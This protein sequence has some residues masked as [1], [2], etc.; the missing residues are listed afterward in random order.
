MQDSIITKY[1]VE[2][3]MIH[4]CN[5]WIIISCN[6]FPFV[7]FILIK[8][9]KINLKQH[10]RSILNLLLWN[11]NVISPWRATNYS[12][13]Q[14]SWDIS[15]FFMFCLGNGRSVQWFIEQNSV[16][17]EQN[18][19]WK[20][21]CAHCFSNVEVSV[22]ARPIHGRWG[23][24]YKSMLY[25]TDYVFRIIVVLDDDATGKYN[26]ASKSDATIFS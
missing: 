9:S 18:V 11:K 8:C 22:V 2:T 23:F 25:Y 5:Y 26:S 14:K 10:N 3:H 19:R 4:C 20:H 1:T 15:Q 21:L 7:I 6:F 24:F 13:G 12:T 17:W 16:E